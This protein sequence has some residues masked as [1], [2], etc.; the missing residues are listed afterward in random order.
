MTWLRRE[1]QGTMP[2]TILLAL[3]NHSSICFGD[4]CFVMKL[5]SIRSTCT[6]TGPRPPQFKFNNLFNKHFSEIIFFSSKVFY[7]VKTGEVEMDC[8]FKLVQEM[9]TK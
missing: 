3:N 4:F 7:R 9:V 8:S 2:P 5:T 6:T 1:K